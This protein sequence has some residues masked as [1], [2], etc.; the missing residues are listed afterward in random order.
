[1]PLVGLFATSGRLV[2]PGPAEGFDRVD[3]VRTC[4]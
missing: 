4:R 1:V 2:A 3:V